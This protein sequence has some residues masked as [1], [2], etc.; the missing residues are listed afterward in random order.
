LKTAGDLTDDS[1]RKEDTFNEIIKSER[2]SPIWKP[3]RERE[4]R[5]PSLPSMTPPEVDVRG[6][7]AD[8]RTPQII[9][10][11]DG[12]VIE[13]KVY[14]RL[15]ARIVRRLFAIESGRQDKKRKP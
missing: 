14:E 7:T 4:S 12:R 9:S 6:G 3:Q 1:N 2:N 15:G 8:P 11:L 5:Q 13:I 10:R